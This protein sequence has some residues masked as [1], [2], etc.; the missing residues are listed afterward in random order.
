MRMKM[1]A[2]ALAATVAGPALAEVPGM[3][4]RPLATP[5]EV[6]VDA[7]VASNADAA[8]AISAATELRDSMVGP[9]GA[10]APGAVRPS[11]SLLEMVSGRNEMVTVARNQP[12]RFN[13]PFDVPV[14]RFAN[15]LTSVEVEG[16]Q[17][18]VTTASQGP[19]TLYIEDEANAEN[20]FVL[21]LV[22]REV[23]AVAITL[24]MLGMRPTLAPRSVEAA[25]A[26]E[27]ADH[28]SAMIRDTFKE[29]AQG[30]VPAGFGLANVADRYAVPECLMPGLRIDPGQ[31][32]TGSRIVVYV[33]KVTNPTTIPQS[34]DE[35]GCAADNVLAVAA[36][37][38]V[39]LMPGQATELFIAT[40]REVAKPANQRPS[41]IH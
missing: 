15:D 39:E 3:P 21:T 16:R 20:T 30:R 14:V 32:V 36:W 26:F 5:V 40:R 25:E 17:V 22:P 37:P 10:R 6:P 29:L 13:T 28:F 19:V 27:Q 2:V 31:T 38:Y 33:A 34:V 9:A 12:N 24:R 1:L 8:D 4:T 35:A 11:P 41:L 23:P 7:T 18:Y